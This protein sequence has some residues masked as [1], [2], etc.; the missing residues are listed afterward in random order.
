LRDLATKNGGS[1]TYEDAFQYRE[2]PQKAKKQEPAQVANP[3]VDEAQSDPF[4]NAA[5]NLAAKSRVRKLQRPNIWDEEETTPFVNAPSVSVPKESKLNAGTI[6]SDKFQR[7]VD[8][9]DRAVDK[10]ANGQK[11]TSGRI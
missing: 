6:D 10:F 11:K 8:K 1:G 2:Q 7:A 9:F 3:I 5:E 4:K